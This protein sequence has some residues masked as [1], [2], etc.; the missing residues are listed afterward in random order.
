MLAFALDVKCFT[1]YA[2]AIV[3]FGAI[4]GEVAYVIGER[5]A[6]SVVF[7]AVT[8]FQSAIIR[9]VVVSGIHGFSPK[10]IK[11]AGWGADSFNIRRNAVI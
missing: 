3:F 11:T 8:A 1:A 2:S 7:A 4:A 6:A 10:K 9:L 5:T